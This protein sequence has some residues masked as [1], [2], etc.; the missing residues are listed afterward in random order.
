MLNKVVPLAPA[1]ENNFVFV[2]K[3]PSED[4]NCTGIKKTFEVVSVLAGV[5]R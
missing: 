2:R 3:S 1:K 5:L 4:R